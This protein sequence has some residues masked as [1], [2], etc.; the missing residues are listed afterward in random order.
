ML[1]IIED[2]GKNPK[3]EQTSKFTIKSSKNILS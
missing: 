2:D 3:V 1:I